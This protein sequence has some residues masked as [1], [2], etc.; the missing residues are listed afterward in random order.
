[1]RITWVTAACWSGLVAV[2]GGAWG[3]ETLVVSGRVVDEQDRPVVRA[4]VATHWDA[5]D[6]SRMRIH[7]SLTDQDGQFSLKVEFW[8]EY[9]PLLAMNSEQTRGGTI[10]L[11][12]R[13]SRSNVVFKLEPLARV[14][15]R[16][17]CNVWASLPSGR[18]C[19]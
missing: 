4:V 5:F 12:P 17:T 1:M 10:I 15:G 19:T 8:Q 6:G 16:F 18:T 7:P 9:L 3:G 11:G 13:S 2:V 14:H